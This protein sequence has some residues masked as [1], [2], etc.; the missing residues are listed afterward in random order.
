MESTVEHR[1]AELSRRR[2]FLG[3]RPT[4]K[5]FD[6]VLADTTMSAIQDAVGRRRQSPTRCRF[7]DALLGGSGG[8]RLLALLALVLKV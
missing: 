1:R 4:R 3:D 7:G 8:L 2:P 5:P 6:L